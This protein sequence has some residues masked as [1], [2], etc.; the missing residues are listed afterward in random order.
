MKTR[1]TVHLLFEFLNSHANSILLLL[2]IGLM[3]LPKNISA[4]SGFSNGHGKNTLVSLTVGLPFYRQASGQLS[5]SEGVEQGYLLQ[6]SIVDDVCEQ[7]Q[8]SNFGFDWGDTLAPGIYYARKYLFHSQFHYDSVVSLSL[9][10]HPFSRISDTVLVDVGDSLADFPGLTSDTLVSHFGCDSIVERFVVVVNCPADTSLVADYG[11]I[12]VPLEVV[13]PSIFPQTSSLQI[14][15]NHTGDFLVGTD[16]AVSWQIIASN[17][18]FYCTQNVR[19]NYP[20]CGGDFVAIDGDGN[21]YETVRVG[22]DC[23]MKQNLRASLYADGDTIPIAQVVMVMGDTVPD[24]QKLGLLYSW[25]SAVDI[26]EGSDSVPE[27][28]ADGYVQGVC[29]WGWHL[30]SL[31]EMA[32]LLASPASTL[33]DAGDLWIASSDN[34]SGFS[35]LPSGTFDSRMESF[36][37]YRIMASFWTAENV[38]SNSAIIGEISAVCNETGVEDAAKFD[39]NSVRCVKD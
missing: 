6:V 25:Y 35:A 31:A 3:L 34:A 29:P 26:P 22:A 19:V 11:E 14:I 37:N 7:Q 15:S 21:H 36:E 38:G 24:W 30:P 17:D 23:W 18:T 5:I 20:P 4:Q 13:T 12:S 9:Y 32:V 27:A 10:V 39:G 28:N 2:L 33:R 8:Y 1:R 16:N